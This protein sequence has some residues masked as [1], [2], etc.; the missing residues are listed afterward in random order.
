MDEALYPTDYTDFLTGGPDD[1][2]KSVAVTGTNA[3]A[4]SHVHI[5]ASKPANA[6]T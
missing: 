6:S 4:E 2:E 5:R 3:V 1:R